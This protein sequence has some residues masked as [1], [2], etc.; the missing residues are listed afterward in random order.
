MTEICVADLV[1]PICFV[2]DDGVKLGRVAEQAL[3]RG[4]NVCLDFS[5]VTMLA[6]AFLDPAIGLLYG[7][8]DKD[9]LARRLTWKG[10]DSID[11]AVLRLVQRNAILFFSATKAQQEA[12]LE[13]SSRYPVD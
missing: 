4:D 1:G 11:E 2:P 6:A 7:T 12:L 9:D 5:K 10:L 13:A 8:F 3:A